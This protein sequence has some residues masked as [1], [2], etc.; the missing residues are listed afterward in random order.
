VADFAG[1]VEDWVRNSQALL[2]GVFHESTQRVVEIMQT[3]G[4]SKASVAKAV[5]KGTGLGKNGRAS[6]KAMGPVHPANGGGR[7]PVDT[8]FLWHSLLASTDGMPELRDS[9]TGENQTF[10]YNAGPIN[11]TINNTPLGQ[12]IWLGY[13][14]KYAARVNY[15]Y[16]YMFV[17]MA[18]QQWPQIVNQVQAEL[19]GRLNA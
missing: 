3:P 4:P 18:V 5:E 8:G 13:T 16:G 12:T 1:Q 17:D 19:K 14:A 2:E 6:K 10:T 11:L 9:P 15:D 7:L